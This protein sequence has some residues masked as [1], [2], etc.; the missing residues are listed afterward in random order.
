MRTAWYSNRAVR[1]LILTLAVCLAFVGCKGKSND[2]ES[3]AKMAG[4]SAERDLPPEE[5]LYQQLRS[6]AFQLDA[7]T[8]SL[9]EAFEQAK[10]GE[11]KAKGMTKEGLQDV[12]DYLDS[13]G[14]QISDYTE[15]PASAKAVQE[16]ISEFEALKHKALQAISDSIR[17][18]EEAQGI[19]SSLEED[20]PSFPAKGLSN[21]ISVA[22]E[23]LIGALEA[24]GGKAD[25][26]DSQ[27]NPEASDK[28]SPK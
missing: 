21:L 18:L 19:A 7:A 24:L 6:C 10:D 3:P 26:D 23:D 28:N 11:S 15:E 9:A 27:T 2:S 17:D 13:A 1:G 5:V 25:S 22:R 8:E 12:L 20:D 4:V 16:K 14:S